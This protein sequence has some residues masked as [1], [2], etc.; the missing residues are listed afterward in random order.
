MKPRTKLQHQVV[1]LSRFISPIS[2][3]QK[4]W[5]YDNCLKKV[6]FKGKKQT[7]C[8][9]CGHKWYGERGVK[10]CVCPECK[11]K[12]EI[13]HTQKRVHKQE[14]YFSILDICNGFQVV[15]YFDL[16]SYHK[17]GERVRY[18]ASEILQQWI[19]P[20]GKYEFFGKRHRVS[21]Y[22]DAWLGDFEI[23]EKNLGRYNYHKKDLYNLNSNFTYP[24]FTVL[25][26]IKRNGFTGAFHSVPP[27]ELF[28]SLMSD[29]VVESLLKMKQLDLMYH[30]MAKE[31][32]PITHYW[33]SIKICQRN[34]Y[35]VKE[36]VMW[37]D[38]LKLLNDFGKDLR[39]PKYVCPVNLKKEHDKYV[40]KKRR[41]DLK[42]KEERLRNQINEAE[43]KY[44]KN[45][46]LYLG[47]AIIDKEITITPLQ[48]VKEFL[49]EGEI[50]DHCV[51][52]NEYY[53]KINS[54]VLSA[55]VNGIRTE[56]IEISLTNFEI[57]QCQGH[58]NENSKY[59]DRI[60][61]L[62]K[63]NIHQIQKLKNE[64][65]KNTHTKPKKVSK[66]KA[67]AAA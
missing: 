14:T 52:S 28:R 61:R 44:K 17:L 43:K 27:L 57:I 56:T 16:H 38:Y 46:K 30:Y 23:R 1:D 64:K 19:L 59:H 34:G 60:L 31:K 6:A 29:N 58:N 55:K 37:F 50:L 20:N 62:M 9:Q 32:F 21:W 63:K 40:E 47:I 33:N 66:A 26:E 22:M 13:T 48:S 18:S 4:E 36:P 10:K 35:Q 3:T 2:S 65:Q 8:L 11:A 5:A 45:K 24:K 49:E 39:N 25:P 41:R 15:R 12:L 7:S 54:L 67:T 42:E 53:D 51:F